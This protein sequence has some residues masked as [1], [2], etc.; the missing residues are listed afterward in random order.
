MGKLYLVTGVSSGIGFAIAELLLS[1][2]QRVLGI[3]RSCSEK[4]KFLQSKYS[5]NFFFES[6]DLTIELDKL[7]RW[8]LT[9]SKSHGRFSGYVHAAGVLEIM[10]LRFNTHQKMV[11][12]FTL[13]VFSALN[14]A[15]GVADKRSN[16]GKGT[17]IVLLSSIAAKTGSGG[18][19]SYSASKAALDGAMRALAKELSTDGIRV[20][21]VICGTVKTEMLDAHSGIYTQEYLNKMEAGYPLGLGNAE[22]IANAVEFLLS[23]KSKWITGS[24]LL[25]DGGISL[26]AHE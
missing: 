22:D 16:S 24:E 26:G 2:K 15:K 25:I 23:D 9:L 7:P 5:D 19:V 8:V 13:N 21:S 1:Q 14:L 10:P 18:L 20:N 4:V 6:K 17:S 11:D 12:I 3:S